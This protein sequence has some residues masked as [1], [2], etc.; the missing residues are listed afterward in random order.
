MRAGSW[1]LTACPEHAR[2]QPVPVRPGFE[3]F[4]IVRT[5]VEGKMQVVSCRRYH[6]DTDSFSD[7]TR[8]RSASRTDRWR[9]SVAENAVRM[10]RS[11]TTNAPEARSADHE[12]SSWRWLSTRSLKTTIEIRSLKTRPRALACTDVVE[13]DIDSKCSSRTPSF[14]STAD[15]PPHG[16]FYDAAR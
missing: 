6:R 12:T 5:F 9:V 14:C 11:S 7:A 3:H 2:G 1:L 16:E 8:N 15:E 4:R 10:G 13:I